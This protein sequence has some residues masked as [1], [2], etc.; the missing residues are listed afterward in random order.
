[1]AKGLIVLDAS[2]FLNYRLNETLA[3]QAKSVLDEWK[4]NRTSLA[5]PSLFQYEVIASTRKSVYRQR[6][7][8]AESVKVLEALFELE[9]TCYLDDALLKRAYDI[10]TQLSRPTAYDAQY[11]ALAERLDCEFWTADKKLY[12]AAAPQISNVRWLGSTTP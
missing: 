12:N 7:T 9:I 11:L 1:M 2:V 4:A 5:A 6:I 3:D 8:V 10:A